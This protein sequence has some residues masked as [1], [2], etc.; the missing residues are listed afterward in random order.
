MKRFI[1]LV[2]AICGKLFY[3]FVDGRLLAELPGPD[4]FNQ[5]KVDH[6]RDD[7]RDGPVPPMV[8]I[9]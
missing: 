8:G 9:F 2:K 4:E 3:K 6:P 5:H 7:P 1:D